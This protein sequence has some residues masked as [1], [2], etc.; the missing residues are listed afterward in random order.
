MRAGHNRDVVAFKTCPNIKW[1]HGLFSKQ[2]FLTAP[3][4]GIH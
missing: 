1:Q 2:S 3:E 4:T